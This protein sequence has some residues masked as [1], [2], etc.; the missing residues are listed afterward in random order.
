MIKIIHTAD[1]HFGVE[2]YGKVDPET[3]LH[4]RLLDFIQSFEYCIATAIR[5][6]ADIF[7]LA[8]DAYKTANPSPTHQKYLLQSLLKL[9]KAG[10][11]IIIVVGN[12][13]HPLSFGKAHALDV[14]ASLPVQGFY[15]FSKPHAVKIQTKNGPVQVVGIPWPL[16]QNL[17]TK[18]D[19]RY[20]DFEKITDHISLA[21]CNIIKKIANS[22]DPSIPSILTGHLTVNDGIFSGSEKKAI[23]GSDP[24]FAVNDLA[25]PPFNYVAL[26]HLHRHQS[27]NLIGKTPVIYSGSIDRIDF[28]EIRDTKG[29]V[30]VNIDTIS[31]GYDYERIAIVNFMPIPIRAML[32]INIYLIAEGDHFSKQILDELKKYT[33]NNAIV[34]IFYHIPPGSLDTVD[35]TL[36][37]R[38]I[39]HAWHIAGII[40][41]HKPL[42]RNTQLCTTANNQ[43]SHKELLEKYFLG[44]GFDP[45]LIKKLIIKGCCFLDEAKDLE[46]NHN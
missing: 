17:L 9:Q 29:F 42:Q 21:T 23:F 14:Y 32:E 39:S 27:L 28:G 43:L 41:I 30:M 25:I 18:E 20:K 1:V 35:I 33:L 15:V 31:T 26:G 8:G 19:F 10:I 36:I 6:Q 34:K 44:K 3:G 46:I 37:Y 5:E 24:L 40:P 4:T 11:A 7:I 2:N 45:V 16:R 12:H 22:L 38:S 13:D